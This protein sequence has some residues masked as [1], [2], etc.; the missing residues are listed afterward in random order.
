MPVG[1]DHYGCGDDACWGVDAPVEKSC[2]CFT[3]KG[4]SLRYEMITLFLKLPAELRVM[5][6]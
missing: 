4:E 1:Y 2:L 6:W 3:G 5:I